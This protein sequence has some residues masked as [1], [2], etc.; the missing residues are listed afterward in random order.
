[1]SQ[2][3]E[4]KGAEQSMTK[5]CLFIVVA[6][7]LASA[8]AMDVE[9]QAVRGP[10]TVTV[11]NGSITLHALLWRPS[12]HGPFPSVLF[13]HGSGRTPEELKR[14]G[15]YEQQAY[16]LGPVFARHG[17]VFLYLFRRGVG[18]SADQGANA[19]DR[20]NAEFVAH[21]QQARNA[22]QLRLLENDDMTDALSGLAFLNALPE[23]D[24]KRIAV[25]GHSFGAA[26]TFLLAA[27]EPKLRA[28]VI[29]SGAGYSW[30]R[31]PELRTRLAA[32]AVDVTA[33]VFF[34]H[35]ANDYSL[36][37]GK[38]LD[39]RLEQLGK[40]HLLKIYPPVGHTLDE[41]HGFLYLGVP[42]W[43]PDV[44]AFLTQHMGG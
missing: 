14:L 21:G 8:L 38:D 24:A 34:I 4:I 22:L 3:Y 29:F 44:F 32:A 13:N 10:E 26:L 27:R 37:P 30:D 20:M 43:E 36:A 12:G 15:S 6:I 17:Y 11:R 23:V 39:A 25:I 42:T 19:V 33:P 41:G 35:A 5:S 18:L 9:A 31:S 28:V 7:V 1:M 16:V 2:T 40:P